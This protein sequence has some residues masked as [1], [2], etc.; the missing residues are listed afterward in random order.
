[1]KEKHKSI[2]ASI[3]KNVRRIRKEQKLSQQ[4][5]ANKCDVDRAKISTIETAKEDFHFTTLLELADALNVKPKELL[6]F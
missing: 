2:F 4:D 3:G 1:M 6:D 5:L